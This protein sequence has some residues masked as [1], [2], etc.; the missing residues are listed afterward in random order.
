MRGG[1]TVTELIA[2]KSP[3]RVRTKERGVRPRTHGAAVGVVVGFD[4][5]G[6]AMVRRTG[7]QRAFPA[8]T[9]VELSTADVGREVVMAFERSNRRRPIILGRICPP[10]A[11]GKVDVQVDGRAVV[12]S[13]EQEITLRCGRASI[14]LTRAGKVLINGAYLL[15]RSTGVNRIKGGSVQIN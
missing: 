4:K 11:G 15:S 2:P 8:R 1:N 5:Q 13:G 6:R 12:V 3:S 7:S 10:N 9:V 14:T